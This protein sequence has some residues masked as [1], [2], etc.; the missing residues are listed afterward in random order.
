M[1]EF[2]GDER[3][4]LMLGRYQRLALEGL[5]FPCHDAPRTDDFLFSVPKATT[6]CKTQYF[7]VHTAG[8]SPS[9]GQRLNRIIQPSPIAR[10]SHTAP[11]VGRR[12]HR[13]CEATAESFRNED[14]VAMIGFGRSEE[15]TSELQSLAYL[16][17]RLL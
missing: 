10:G 8:R 13:T 11:L 16:V 14:D 9:C 6:A 15:H 12:P 4:D 5:G 2:M 7:C 1:P 17:C 3:D